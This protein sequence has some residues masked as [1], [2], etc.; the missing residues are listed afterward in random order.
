MFKSVYEFTKVFSVLFFLSGV[1]FLFKEMF[2]LA[3]ITMFSFFAIKFIDSDWAFDNF[4]FSNHNLVVILITFGLIFVNFFTIY[5]EL[6]FSPLL[7]RVTQDDK[8]SYL[9]YENALYSSIEPCTEAHNALI[10]RL[11]S[12]IPVYNADVKSA[13]GYCYKVIDNID[14]QVIPEQFPSEVKLL[15]NRTKDEFKKIAVNLATY[16]YSVDMPQQGLILRVKESLEEAI[17]NMSRVRE[18]MHMT[19]DLEEH[20]RTFIQL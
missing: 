16:N 14:K 18:I 8:A 3:F 6:R 11:N 10:D 12:N 13:N 4:K 15:C 9:V 2:F 1:F 7:T 17:K 20:K 5:Q 19:E